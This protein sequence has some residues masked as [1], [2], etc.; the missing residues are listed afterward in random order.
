MNTTI[1]ITKSKTIHWIML[2]RAGGQVGRFF[3]KK[4]SGG[5]GTLIRDPRVYMYLYVF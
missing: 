5:G 3:E 1:I 4:I 2:I